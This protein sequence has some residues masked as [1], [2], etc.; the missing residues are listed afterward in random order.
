VAATKL[1]ALFPPSCF[2]GNR[3]K[4]I[5]LK[6]PSDGPGR[7]NNTTHYSIKVSFN[8]SGMFRPRSNLDMEFSECYS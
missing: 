3:P 8:F 7:R 2:T 6:D 5:S 1:K 4:A